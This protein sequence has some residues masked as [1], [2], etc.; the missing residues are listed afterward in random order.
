MCNDGASLMC[1]SEGW[2]PAPVTEWL[3]SQGRFLTAEPVDMH[4][5]PN[6][7]RVKQRLHYESGTDHYVCR[8]RQKDPRTDLWREIVKETKFHIPGGLPYSIV[9]L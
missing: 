6:G 5:G 2:W 3:D 1:H 8:F 9:Y 4:L 7:F